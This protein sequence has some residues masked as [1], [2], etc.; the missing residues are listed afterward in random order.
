MSGASH[1][2]FLALPPGGRR[3]DEV[4]WLRSADG[5]RL[6]AGLW[7]AERPRGQAL[8]LP[9]RTEFLEQQA[10]PAAGLAGRGLDVVSLDWRGQGLADRVCARSA[11]HGHVADFTDYAADLDALLAEPAVASS[12]LP[13]V[14]LGNS[15][16]G[17]VALAALGRGAAGPVRA[18]I[19]TAPMFGIA[20]GPVGVLVARAVAGTAGRIGMAE[21]WPPW[22]GAGV[23][24]ALGPFEAN[25]VTGDRQ[26]WD[27]LAATARAH[28]ALSIGLPTFGWVA[29]AIRAM[30]ALRRA[31][32]QG[33]PCLVLVGSAERVADIGAVTAGAARI[34]A[35]LVVIEGARHLLLA[36][37]EPMRAAAWAAIDGFLAEVLR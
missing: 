3:P 17:A 37:A 23:P 2:P 20:A 12:A 32:P 35:R 18:A 9:G 11:L 24:F 5:V 29:A 15:M 22:P 21:R 19:L 14:V 7:R 8:L 13:R 36:E 26:Y 6:R 16:G 34:G 27:W 25:P 4:W 10:L 31:G 30:D 1:A 28:P 33:C